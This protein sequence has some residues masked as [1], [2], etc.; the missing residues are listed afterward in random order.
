MAAPIVY[1]GAAAP[2]EPVRDALFTGMKFWVGHRVPQRGNYVRSIENNGGKVVPLE[3]NADYL[4]S[5][6]ARKDAPPGSYSFKFIE[7][8]VEAGALQDFEKYLCNSSEPDSRPVGSTIAARATRTPFTRE[9]DKILTEW[10]ARKER[11]GAPTY[12]YEI[13]KKLA[14]KH[15]R[16]TY[17]SWRDRWR[18]ILQYRRL[19]VPDGEESPT[20][21]TPSAKSPARP[22]PSQPGTPKGPGVGQASTQS[23]GEARPR[24]RFSAEEDQLLIEHIK[25]SIENNKA[26]SGNKI[27]LDLAKDFPQHTMHSW[28]DRWLKQLAPQLQDEIAKWKSERRPRIQSDHTVRRGANGSRGP[29]ETPEQPQLSQVREPAS[30]Q[31]AADDIVQTDASQPSKR[32]QEEIA[33]HTAR[34]D[35]GNIS[36]DQ[37]QTQALRSAPE[38]K[39]EPQMETENNAQSSDFPNQ[40]APQDELQSDA[41]MQTEKEAFFGDYQAYLEA[42]E[43]PIEIWPRIRGRVVDLWDLWQAV[44]SLKMDPPE[45]DWQQVAESLHFDWVEQETVPEELRQCYEKYLAGFE[46]AIVNFEETEDNDDGD[47]NEAENENA[48]PDFEE[49]LPSSPPMMPSLKRSFADANLSSDRAYPRST[50]KRTRIDRNSEIPSTPDDVNGT[51]HLRGQTRA[52]TTPTKPS[53]LTSGLLPVASGQTANVM[54]DDDEDDEARDEVQEL[55]A[56]R[57]RKQPIE[58]ETQNFRYDPETQ[59]FAFDT[60]ADM[61]EESQNNITPSQQLLQES[62]A[63]SSGLLETSPVSG[64]QLQHAVQTT[65]TPKRTIRNPFQDDGSDG[66]ASGATSNRGNEPPTNTIM[67]QSK[68]RS[69]PQKW[70]PKRSSPAAAANASSPIPSRPPPPPPQSQPPRAAAPTTPRPQ[71]AAKESPDDV[72]DRFCSLGYPRD[73]VL[74][75]LQATTWR[76]GDAGQVMEMLHQRGGAL[77]QK[78]HGVWTPRDDDALRFLVNTSTSASAR[79]AKAE[80]KR[81]KELRRLEAKHGPELIALRRKYLGLEEWDGA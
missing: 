51:S 37:S 33:Q 24:A 6:P 3:K 7:D 32:A 22:S 41:A 78:T 61:E 5:D 77:P 42:E 60:Q 28:R 35:T 1:E 57:T 39:T 45:R 76:L 43:R 71:S 13:Y 70:T 25:E 79:D 27:Y 15:P 40:A 18:R 67:P 64:R 54:G 65:P 68:R 4:I 56:I 59:T 29:T 14:A 36:N 58:P 31:P 69:L 62:D 74:Q 17:Q 30:V 63:R 50:P 19:P 72:I 81:A 53:K 80:K 21:A 34:I 44:I 48:A 47:D 38:I 20:P 66:E 16:H 12:G 46:E 75:A 52:E 10:V 9:D 8:S 49:P 23:P 73:I 26:I 11:E 2:S 55:P